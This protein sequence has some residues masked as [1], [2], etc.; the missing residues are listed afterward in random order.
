MSHFEFDIDVTYI[1]VE[2]DAAGK[3]FAK[4]HF[5]LDNH[6]D[7][8]KLVS[9]ARLNK[10]ALKRVDEDPTPEAGHT[11]VYFGDPACCTCGESYE[12]PPQE[13]ENLE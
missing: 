13:A 12:A 5:V 4:L 1:N 2:A 6:D 7:M 9:W 11:H 10:L 3:P 8:A